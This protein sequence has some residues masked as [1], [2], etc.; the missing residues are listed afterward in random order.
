MNT[1][2]YDEIRIDYCVVGEPAVLLVVDYADGIER[3][4]MTDSPVVKMTIEDARNTCIETETHIIKTFG[5]N[6]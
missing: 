1:K 5:F 4:I 6:I 3:R 2:I